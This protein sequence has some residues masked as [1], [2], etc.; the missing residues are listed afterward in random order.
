MIPSRLPDAGWKWTVGKN[1]CLWSGSRCTE[2]CHWHHLPGIGHR[3]TTAAHR[4]PVCELSTSRRDE[5][6]HEHHAG[7]LHQSYCHY[8]H[9][10]TVAAQL[11]DVPTSQ[12][13]SHLTD[14]SQ[15]TLVVK[16]ADDCLWPLSNYVDSTCLTYTTWKC[17][18]GCIYH[19]SVQVV[20]S[21][22][23]RVDHEPKSNE[24]VLVIIMAKYFSFTLYT[25]ILNFQLQFCKA[26]LNSLD[27]ASMT[28]TNSK[29]LNL[30][31]GAY[32]PL[33]PN[34]KLFLQLFLHPY[35]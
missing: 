34:Y 26:T 8:T 28:I 22:S 7:G 16:S 18:K 2:G 12:K 31:F 3:W 10:S 30:N 11:T 6:Q 19:W 29:G 21:A 35:A 32:R 17:K 33:P 15:Y 25:G 4:P 1:D 24:V 20:A 27:K 14:E 5:M 13:W 23:R 9:K